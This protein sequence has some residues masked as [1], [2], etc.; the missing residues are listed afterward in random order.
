MSKID[1]DVSEINQYHKSAGKIQLVHFSNNEFWKIIGCII[2]E[3]TYGKKGY[4]L[5]YI[6]TRK[7]LG[8]AEG[9]SYKYACG[10]TDL[11]HLI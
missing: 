6:T 8:K 9:Q 4:G 5:W 2:L 11:L 10:N 7:Y 3:V 1:E